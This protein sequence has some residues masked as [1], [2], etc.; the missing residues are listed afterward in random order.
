MLASQEINKSVMAITDRM[1]GADYKRWTRRG[2]RNG[3][4]D[5]YSGR[6]HCCRCRFVAR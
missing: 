2:N 3:R 6:R 1:A 5:R 4:Q